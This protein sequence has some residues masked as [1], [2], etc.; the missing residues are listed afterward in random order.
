M[1]NR[2]CSGC[3]FNSAENRC[4]RE[5]EWQWKGDYYP[6][7]RNEYETIKMNI[8]YEFMIKAQ[9]QVYEAPAPKKASTYI[10]GP[11]YQPQV[12]QVRSF[13]ELAIEQQ[14]KIIK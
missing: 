8:E 1:D 14:Q 7:T 11:Q 13:Y 10:R 6:L 4:K 3:V 2:T 12:R 5:L 9:D